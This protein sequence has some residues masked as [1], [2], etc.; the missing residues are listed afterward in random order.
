MT[1]ELCTQDIASKCTEKKRVMVFISTQKQHLGSSRD[2]DGMQGVKQNRRVRKAT[3][4]GR[5]A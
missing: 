4:S 1:Q 3:R 2:K 5:A